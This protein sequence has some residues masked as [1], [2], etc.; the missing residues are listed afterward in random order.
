MNAPNL[1]MAKIVHYK[2]CYY[3][4]KDILKKPGARVYVECFTP[5]ATV[6]QPLLAFSLSRYLG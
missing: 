6:D 5:L 1:K 2:E 3:Y 4:H